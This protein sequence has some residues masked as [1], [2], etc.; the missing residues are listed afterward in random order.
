[1]KKRVP[2]KVIIPIAVLLV[3]AA[4]ILASYVLIPRPLLPANG[5]VG[6]NNI[7]VK[8]SDAEVGGLIDTDALMDILSNGKVTTDLS[9][10]HAFPR[11]DYPIQIS[12]I[13]D[14]KPVYIN[15]GEEGFMYKGSSSSSL[16]WNI[17]EGGRM[18]DEVLNLVF[19]SYLGIMG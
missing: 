4:A 6:L 1:M 18:Y 12:L 2:R 10:M 17:V 9:P 14:N 16:K 11:D 7:S 8:Y 13:V 19:S 3:I 5:E 15:L